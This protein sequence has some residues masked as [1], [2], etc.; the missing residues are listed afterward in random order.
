MFKSTIAI[1]AHGD[2]V[3]RVQ[4][5]LSRLTP[6]GQD[7]EPI[8]DGM[9]TFG[10]HLDGAVRGFQAAQG[11][12]V[13]GIV[14]PVTWGKLPPYTESS[15]RLQRGSVGPAV[16]GLQMWLTTF[17]GNGGTSP[18][19]IDGEFGPLTEAAL[20]KH[21]LIDSVDD[22]LW[23]SPVQDGSVPITDPN[24]LDSLEGHCHLLFMR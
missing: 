24:S 13:D 10:P 21:L 20:Y 22:H 1:G 15:G 3:R 6:R 17:A 16:A 9:G 2:D 14:G 8:Q 4:R 12:V 19:P 5:A 7:F 11:L 23:L 18:G